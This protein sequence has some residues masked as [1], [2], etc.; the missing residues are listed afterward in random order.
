MD[1]TSDD[2]RKRLELKD[3]GHELAGLETG[4]MARFGVGIAREQELKEEKR[5]ER[6]YRDA[7]DRLLATDPEYRRMYEELGNALSTA[8]V[9]ADQ[10][11]ESIQAA[12]SA[13]QEANQDMRN[14]APKI[15]GKAVF[16][17]ADGRVV[18]EDGNEIDVA[19][20]AGIIWP[21]NAPS[22]EDYFAGVAREG[23]LGASL[24]NWQT[25]RNDSLGDIRDRYDDRDNPM[26]KSD[27]QSALEDI[28]AD[29]PDSPLALSSESSIEVAAKPSA[30]P[31]PTL[32]D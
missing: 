9:N 24:E 13:Q 28:E 10:I 18:D 30:V 8:E 22:A 20:A 27:M 6:A 7:L 15:D 32:G 14:G 23:E 5:K 2:E 4:R 17:H 31:I 12:L 11:I 3:H 19:F 25:Y 16:R 29:A 21:E 26:S 1:E